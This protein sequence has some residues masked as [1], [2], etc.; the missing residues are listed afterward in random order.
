MKLLFAV[1]FFVGCFAGAVQASEKAWVLPAKETVVFRIKWLGITAGEITSEI[2]G[3]TEIKG[4]KAYRIEVTAKTVGLCSK[5]YRVE[6]HFVSYLDVEHL[7]SLRHEIHRREGHYAKDAEIDFD[8]EKHLAHFKNLADGRERSF[9]IPPDTQD[10]VTA[11]YVARTF[12]LQTGRRFE[13]KVCNSEKN[14]VIDL[15]IANKTKMHT[16][17]NKLVEVVRLQ[18]RAHFRNNVVREGRLSGYVES[19]PGHA[20]VFITIKAPVFTRLTAT[21]IK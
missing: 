7:Y 3:L 9:A 19:A 14:Y 20:P 5:L 1:I 21:R 13:I 8:Q 4:R 10:T 17:D 16:A 15:A 12:D 6:D 18:P 11:A 2:K